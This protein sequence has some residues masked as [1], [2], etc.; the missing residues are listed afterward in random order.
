MEFLGNDEKAPLS[1][2]SVIGQAVVYVPMKGLIDP[3]VE[4]ARLNKELEKLTKQ[5][6]QI[7]NK[8]ANESF[9]AKAPPAVVEGEKAKL[10]E[11]EGQIG[12]VR[13]SVEQ[14]NNM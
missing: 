10:A 13:E 5:Y 11:L 7:A 3:T 12:K 2:S 6:D 9:V 14:I 4:L 8:L 1:S